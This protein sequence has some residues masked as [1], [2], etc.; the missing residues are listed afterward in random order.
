VKSAYDL[1]VVGAGPA[2]LTAAK[3]AAENGL[4]VALIERKNSVDE[5]LRMCGMMIVSLS[6]PYMGERVV[7]NA[8]AGLLC[9]PHHGFSVKYDGPTKDFFAWNIY[10]PGGEKI[11]FGDYAANSSKGK[12]GRA[13]AVYDKSWFL[14]GLLSE[15]RNLGVQ[16]LAGENVIDVRKKADG[17]EVQTASGKQLSGVF[18]VAADGRN[19]R[20]ARVMGMNKNRGFFG[21]VT[22]IGYEMTNL[23]LPEPDA[24]HMPLVQS[25]DPPMLGFIVPRAWNTDGEDTWLVMI[26]NVDPNTDHES[27]LVNLTQKSRFAPWFKNSRTVR[28]CGCSGN[29]YA[30]IVHPFKDNVLFAGDSG[31]CQEA[32]MTGA[33]MSGLK[34]GNAV[35]FAMLEG[36]YNQQG[37]QTYLD[38]WRQYHIEKLDYNVFLKNLYL[39]ILCGDKEIDYIF[40]NIKETLQTVLEPYEVPETLGK[41]MLKVIPIIQKERPELL[42]KLTGFGS[43]P[44]GV[45]LKN[46]IRTGF[47]CSFTT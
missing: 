40:S 29:M 6:G 36:A 18:A 11:A 35:V 31:W 15:C 4:S 30:P 37:V 32:E 5:I 24:L 43:L 38:W 41:A 17:V 34:A 9:F 12:A 8:E 10:S 20:I 28:R 46:T 27:L 21:S 3:V 14:R 2:G 22:S 33:V 19:S 25:G 1:I 42:N 23:N 13:S 39:P 45:V 16:I 26:T 44:P 47:N 7:H